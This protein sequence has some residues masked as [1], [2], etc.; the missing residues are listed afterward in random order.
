M[1]A[2]IWRFFHLNLPYSALF[3]GSLNCSSVQT[4]MMWRLIKVL[5]LLLSLA[6]HS[7]NLCANELVGL[8]PD[9][10]ARPD[11]SGSWEKD[12]RRSDDWEQK[13]NLKLL[14]MR[15]KA[16]RQARSVGERT[17]SRSTSIG[18]SRG[19]SIID[20][21][22]FAE[23]IS[24]SNDLY[25]TQTDSEVRIKRDGEADLICGTGEIPIWSGSQEFGSEVCGWN[26]HQLIFKVNL[27]GNTDILY[28]FVVSP[29][30]ESITLLTTVSYA[31]Q[32]SFDLVQFF[33]RYEPAQSLF[34]CRQTLTRGKVCSQ[35][36]G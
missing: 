31:Q 4:R 25:I 2:L 17:F 10:G 33:N 24:R 26:N 13:I 21:A 5:P 11:F 15:R 30:G 19:A 8:P 27:P 36:K 14:E 6:T 3:K 12:Y 22:R 16:E 28:R 29:G 34:S 35:K 18:R 32:L 9:P 20:L 7:A 23:L 1:R